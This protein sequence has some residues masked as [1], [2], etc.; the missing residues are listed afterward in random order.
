[1][2]PLHG[3]NLVNIAAMQQKQ[4][5]LESVS[6]EKKALKYNPRKLKDNPR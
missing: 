5:S 1:M 4:L 3:P 6:L 2:G